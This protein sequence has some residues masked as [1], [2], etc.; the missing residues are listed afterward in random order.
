MLVGRGR[1]IAVL[2]AG[3]AQLA[4]GRGS[5]TLISGEPGIGKTRLANEL[6]AIAGERGIRI[7]WGR[8]WEAGGAPAFWPWQEALGALG[9]RFPDGGNIATA[10]PAQA[11]FALF[12]DVA[13]VVAA[14]GAP[15]L[16]VLEDLHAADHSSVLLLEF[17]MSHVRAASIAIVGTYRDLEAS[18]RPDVADVLTRVGR[19]GSVLALA[20]LGADEVEAVVRQSVDDVDA[21]LIARMFDTTQG[22]PLFLTELLRQVRVGEASSAIPLGVREIIRQRLGLVAPTARRVLDAAAV[23]GVEL[24]AQHLTRMCPNATEIDGAVASGLIT[25]HGDRL[26]F[27]HAL[28]RE[29]LYHDLAPASRRALHGEAARTLRVTGATAAEIA[30]HL[31][32]SGPDAADDAIEHSIAAARLALDVYAFEDARA[33]LERAR[34]VVPDGPPGR[35][36]RARVLI[37]LGEVSLRSGDSKGR[38]LC[39]E[40]ADIARELGDATLLA[41]AGLGYGSV[42]LVGGVDPVMVSILEDALAGLPN[43]DSGLRA[44]TMARLASARQP[45]RS[46]MRDR[47]VQLALAAVDMGRRCASRRE[48]LE[49]L[50]S[51]SGVL[52][53]NADPRLRMRIA[54]EQIDLAESLGDT[55]RLIAGRVRLAFDYLELADLAGYEHNAEAYDRLAERYG[56]VADPWRVPLMR[57]MLAVSRDNFAESERRQA[58][59]AAISA[60]DPRA[61]RARTFHR[62]CFLGAS[63]RHADMRA[64]IAELNGLWLAM[65]YGEVL[66]DARVASVLMRTG[67]DDE[68]RALLA[69]LPAEAFDEEFNWQSLAEAVWCTADSELAARLL[70]KRDKYANRWHA[71]WLD[72]EFIEFPNER[73]IAYLSGIVGDWDAC[74]RWFAV[75]QREVEQLGRR[76]ALARMKFEFGDL[77]IRSNRDLER[78]RGLI[79]EAR[80]LAAELGLSELVA[81]IDRRHPAAPAAKPAQRFTIIREGEYFAFTSASG[82]LRFKATRG[83]TYLAQLVERAGTEVHVLDLVGSQDADRGDAGEVVDSKAMRAYRERADALRDMLDDAEERGDSNGAERAR[84]ELAAL[85]TEIARASGPGGRLRRTESAV[86]RARSAVQRRIKD[87]LDRIAEQDFE[88]GA[89]LRRAVHTGNHCGFKW[90]V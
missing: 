79:V 12:R 40:A 90:N 56:A 57:S 64:A 54:R 21:A 31:I 15:L 72:V 51:A 76:S 27:T 23:L 6:A 49:I 89:W 34:H 52:Y 18:L 36:L 43:G 17:L 2:S 1:E 61:R 55:P 25:R 88:L 87:T 29:A 60:V 11:R 4:S 10:D 53:G 5:V 66:N 20:R 14:V 22:N 86:D 68:V 70:A 30:H 7:A 8:C 67:A 65:P 13:A 62:V 83:F 19:A 75:A 80:A 37:A 84:T 71:Y 9:L 82:T 33:L 46:P 41:A 73:L 39:V 45:S 35:R 38:E 44:R 26:R 32:E 63:E 24:E 77:L 3:L 58:E 85:A 47:D 16:I 59:A 28:Y 42:F 81:L 69:R 50:Q 48:L 74:E 78:A